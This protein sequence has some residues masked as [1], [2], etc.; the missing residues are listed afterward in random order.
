MMF[1]KKS[2]K[3]IK[4][5]R[6]HKKIK[7]SIIIGDYKL[8]KN[9]KISIYNIRLKLMSNLI[10]N[11]AFVETLEPACSRLAFFQVTK[12][13]VFTCNVWDVKKFKL[14]NINLHNIFQINHK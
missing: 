6:R 1:Y 2:R 3:I 13:P 4:Y 8:E 10:S 7:N 9:L 11:V 5:F 14:L 12:L